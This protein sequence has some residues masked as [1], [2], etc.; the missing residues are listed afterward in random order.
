M[1]DAPHSN[2]NGPQ[3]RETKNRGFKTQSEPRARQCR[4]GLPHPPGL[5]IQATRRR[6]HR[7]LEH[8]QT[9][10]NQDIM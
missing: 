4:S 9:P 1:K 8:A 3:T 6:S 7:A 5:A 10:N 2:A